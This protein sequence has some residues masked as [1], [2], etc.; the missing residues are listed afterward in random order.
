M[1]GIVNSNY[2]MPSLGSMGMMGSMGS[3]VSANSMGW[4]A[5]GNGMPFAGFMQQ[6]MPGYIPQT[7]ANFM[8]KSLTQ[9]DGKYGDLGGYTYGTEHKVVLNTHVQTNVNYSL[10]PYPYQQHPTPNYGGFG[11]YGDFGGFGGFGGPNAGYDMG[12]NVMPKAY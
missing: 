4:G 11:G 1:S 7:M 3:M 8:P 2:M 9:I 5:S 6:A 12:P 10:E